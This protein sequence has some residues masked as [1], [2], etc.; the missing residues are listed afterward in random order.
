MGTMRSMAGS[1]PLPAHEARPKARR[2][3]VQ[4][5]AG[6]TVVVLAAAGYAWLAPV[7]QADAARLDRL[8]A[9]HPPKGFDGTPTSQ[10]VV[11]ASQT[12]LS[13][14]AA[15]ATSTATQTAAYAVKWKGDATHGKKGAV[16]EALVAVAPSASDA[17][18]IRAQARTRFLGAKDMTTA[19]YSLGHRFSVPAAPG[20]HGATFTATSSSTTASATAPGAIAE[21][22]MGTGRTAVVLY[23]RGDGGRTRA[24]VVTLAA[25]EQSALDRAGSDVSPTVTSYPLVASVVTVAGTVAALLVVAFGPA[26]VARVRR[27]RLAARQRAVERERLARGRKVVKRHRTGPSGRRPSGRRR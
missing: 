11:P 19:G 25:A 8:V 3:W 2:R 17:A 12:G 10:K 20:S 4:W 6:V 22:V 16:A 18:A 5:S 7:H 21:V 26:L 24:D 27:R 15:A 14:L 9:A 13:R 23:V 1:R